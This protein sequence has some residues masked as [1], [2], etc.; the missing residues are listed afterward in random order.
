MNF[1]L[2][3]GCDVEVGR[4]GADIPWDGLLEFNGAASNASSAADSAARFAP[5][6]GAGTGKSFNRVRSRSVM[7]QFRRT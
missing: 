7:V 2:I 6:R 4:A 5:S 1:L 3:A